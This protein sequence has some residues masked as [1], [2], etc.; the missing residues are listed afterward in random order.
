LNQSP[1]PSRAK[2]SRKK[3]GPKVST[4]QIT[5]C[6]NTAKVGDEEN[7]ESKSQS[8]VQT[9]NLRFRPLQR[10]G[11]EVRKEG[12]PVKSI[13]VATQSSRANGVRLNHCTTLVKE[14]FVE[15]T[16]I[17][18]LASGGNGRRSNCHTTQMEEEPIQSSA[19]PTP[20]SGPSSRL[21]NC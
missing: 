18:T 8:L 20:S 21:K 2:V 4:V 14:T 19:I 10:C 6:N 7:T 3:K 16:S 13:L 9:K 17:P 12:I 15:S 5:S 11:D 1:I